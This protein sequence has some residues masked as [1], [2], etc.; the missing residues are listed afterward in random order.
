MKKIL[1]TGGGG[2]ATQIINDVLF[3]KYECHFADANQ[4]NHAIPN[5]IDKSR[6]HSVPYCSSQNYVKDLV[7]LI[8][9]NNIDLLIPGVDE[10]LFLLDEIKS[11]LSRTEILAPDYEYIKKMIDKKSMSQILGRE[12]MVNP[13]AYDLKDNELPYPVFIKPKIGRGSRNVLRIDSVN[14]L[15][16]FFK[17]Y[18]L[19]MDDFVAQNYLQGDEYTV[20]MSANKD[21][22]LMAIVP[23]RVY[24]KKGITIY[25]E[26]IDDNLIIDV[27]HK[28]HNAI[29]TK[30]CYNIQLMK[31]SDNKAIPFEINPRV[32]TTFFMS[33]IAGIDPI[34]NYHETKVSDV[35]QTFKPNIKMRRYWH[36]E[37]I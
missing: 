23:V 21:K 35:L 2:A 1:F 27:C 16:S 26:V 17:L 9:E 28:I 15:N 32:S 8:Y 25:A 37:V 22:D 6:Q 29:P 12:N 18:D 10:E 3:N 7:E 24:E 34:Q 33:F 20:M 13:G 30:G 11:K 31:T 14:Q 5:I 4:N 19:C 36:S